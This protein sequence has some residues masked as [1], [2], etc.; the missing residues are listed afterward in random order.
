MERGFKFLFFA[1]AL[2]IAIIGLAGGW[3]YLIV[4]FWHT[5]FLG[6]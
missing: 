4:V 2:S 5:L 1:F 3:L 6:K